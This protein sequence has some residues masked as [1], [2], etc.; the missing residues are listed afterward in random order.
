MTNKSVMLV[1]GDDDY[2][3]FQ[4][5]MTAH[6]L[7]RQIKW[8]L[9]PYGS[10]ARTGQE[11]EIVFRERQGYNNV[12][13]YLSQQ[14]RITGDLKQLS[15]VVDADLDFAA[16]WQSL[17]DVLV[18]AGYAAAPMQADAQG[19]IL[20]HSEVPD[21]KPRVGV[22]IMPNNQDTGSMETFFALLLPLDDAPW[23]RARLCIEQIPWKSGLSR[24]P[25]SRPMFILGLP[26]RKG[27]D[28]RW[29]KPFPKST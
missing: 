28:C 20:E 9:E 25:S 12:R 18:G 15:V 13:D 23:E 17:R 10:G 8:R 21:E 5:L 1:E 26:G 2:H 6:G 22:W 3:V 16:R 11:N 7:D 14:L 19:L 29:G 24:V 4:H 27:R